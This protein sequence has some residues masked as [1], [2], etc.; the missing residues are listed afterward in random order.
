MYLHISFICCIINIVNKKFCLL[1]P[2]KTNTRNLAWPNITQRI[3]VRTVCTPIA[4]VSTLLPWPVVTA[5]V[6]KSFKLYIYDL[7]FSKLNLVLKIFRVLHCDQLPLKCCHWI[8]RGGQKVT[9]D[10][11]WI[12]LHFRTIWTIFKLQA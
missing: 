11:E 6:S 9:V 3:S 1:T 12:P 2:K 5:I 8:D 10:S 4:C 7:S